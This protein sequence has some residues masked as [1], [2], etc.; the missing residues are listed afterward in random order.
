LKFEKFDI[1]HVM[2]RARTI[3]IAWVLG[4]SALTSACSPTIVDA[5]KTAELGLAILL[6]D[7]SPLLLRTSRVLRT[8]G[9][10]GEIQ[11]SLISGPGALNTSTNTLVAGNTLGTIVI[12][13]TD[14][15]G[16]VAEFEI[17]VAPTAPTALIASGP[18][19]AQ[20]GECA[21]PITLELRDASNQNTFASSP[22]V[23]T[24]SGEEAAAFSSVSSCSDSVDSI[25]V[26]TGSAGAEVYFRS[27]EAKAYA[28]SA[29]STALAPGNHA[30][31]FS[32]GAA[33]HLEIAAGAGQSARVGTAL[34]IDPRVKVVDNFGNPVSGI[35]IGFAVTAGGGV[36]GAASAT[37]N[38]QGFASTTFTMGPNP[39][40]SNNTLVASNNALPGLPKSIT[41]V[42]SAL[43]PAVSLHPQAIELAKGAVQTFA[44][45]GG[46]P[47]FFYEILSGAGS[48]DPVTG[49]FTAP[50]ASGVTQV[51]VS[52]SEGE[53][54][55]ADITTLTTAP[56]GGTVDSSFG[57]SGQAELILTGGATLNEM[58]FLPDGRSII[59]GQHGGNFLV[60]QFLADGLLDPSFGTGGMVEVDFGGASDSAVGIAIQADGK[61]VVAGTTVGPTSG[62]DFAIT[63]LNTNGMIDT[64]FGTNGKTTLDFGDL[65]NDEASRVALQS[66]GNI[67]IV[68]TAL[69]VPFG[70]SVALAR[71]TTSGAPDTTFGTN[72]LLKAV[73]YGALNTQKG[74]EIKVLPDDRFLVVGEYQSDSIVGRFT[75]SGV[76]DVTFGNASGFRMY[77]EMD[78]ARGLAVDGTGKV[79]LAGWKFTDF[80]TRY[81]MTVLRIASDGLLADATFGVAGMRAVDFGGGWDQAYC[82]ELQPDGKILAAGTAGAGFGLIRLSSTGALDNTFGTAGKLT[83][84]SG[85]SA[86]SLNAM[87]LQPDG[88]ILIGTTVDGKIVIQRIWP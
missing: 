50:V 1:V 4:L 60:A 85:G 29:S 41:F 5:V 37:S 51:R 30:L 77:S 15:S 34:S 22:I 49:V 3:A 28:L 65:L 11:L 88:K 27:N 83:I 56:A 31:V 25:N 74:Y 69:S 48:I 8:S 62:S 33:D 55:T 20:A 43:P 72:G 38:A 84:A 39:G 23:I 54:D 86:F 9:G 16:V 59:A 64:G 10:T 67:I 42:A 6:E 73:P 52:D 87:R 7:T 63:R 80:T 68:G 18:S 36:A 71:L 2:R 35:T 61:I 19:S 46:T 32:A 40:T 75:A 58:K 70:S 78:V 21:G 57:V 47:P 45:I 14:S 81:D 76:A 12:R 13:A 17:V 44:A 26:T 66:T 53:S 82:M 24:L 79:L